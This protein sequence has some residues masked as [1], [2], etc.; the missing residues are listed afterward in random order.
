MLL[1]T[2]GDYHFAERLNRN[3]SELTDT[4]KVLSEQIKKDEDVKIQP[5]E[6][7][8][9]KLYHKL[10]IEKYDS[11]D[12][13]KVKPNGL[14]EVIG[15]CHCAGISCTE[16]PEAIYRFTYINMDDEEPKDIKTLLDNGEW[17]DYVSENSSQSCEDLTYDE[18]VK[19]LE[20]LA[21]AYELLD[22]VVKRF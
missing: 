8:S 1:E 17:S 16:D 10:L 11:K 15:Y 7:T 18:Y 9:K 5:L 4:I 21:T 13:C 20:G 3:L 22:E 14:V 6:E 2:R 19:K 12:F